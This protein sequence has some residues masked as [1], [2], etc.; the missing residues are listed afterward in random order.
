VE[1]AD[2]RPHRS[3]AEAWWFDFA[4]PDGSIGGF[5]RL[6]L[7]P[8]AGT[9]WY[10]AA[11]VGDD[12]TYLLVRDEEVP[13]PRRG[14][15][16]VRAE[17]LWSAFECEEPFDHWTIGLEAFAVA[18]DDPEDAWHGERGA[19]VGL[20]FD[21]EWEST[22]SPTT[23]SVP[24]PAHTVVSG[25]ENARGEG[26]YAQACAVHG[27]ILVGAGERF[28][29]DGT[30]WRSHVWGD[31]FNA[32]PVQPLAAGDSVR[33]RAPLMAGDQPIELV[34]ALT[35]GG[36]AAWRARDRGS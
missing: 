33:H 18:L 1:A 10:W 25:T 36:A 29:F 16:E 24:L 9:A 23:F 34:L 21:L 22:E 35:S 28:A 5:V 19:V 32:A 26:G 31:A 7:L 15:M 6:A 20:G 2:E 13:L 4:A 8:A 27:E 12:R 17:G 11:L 3:G 30:G 14:A